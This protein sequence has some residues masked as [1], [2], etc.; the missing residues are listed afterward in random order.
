MACHAGLA[1]IHRQLL[2]VLCMGGSQVEDVDYLRVFI[3]HPRTKIETHPAK[4]GLIR[5]EPGVGYRFP[6]SPA[7]P[8]FPQ[9]TAEVPASLARGAS[10]YGSSLDYIRTCEYI[11]VRQACRPIRLACKEHL[12][13][14]P[15]RHP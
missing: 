7:V 12:G 15:S 4:H 14:I 9:A 5:T 2:S 10:F 1:L 6:D 8:G 11:N 13:E 3:G